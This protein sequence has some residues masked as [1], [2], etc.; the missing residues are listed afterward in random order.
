[1]FHRI[2]IGIGLL[3]LILLFSC[4]DGGQDSQATP[5]ALPLPDTVT[6]AAHIA[7]IIH[8]NCMPCH[9]PGS[10]GPFDLI[11]YEDVFKRKKMV[12]HVTETRYMPPWPADPAYRHFLDEKVLAQ[13]DIDLIGKW[14]QQGGLLGDSQLIPEPPTYPT[15]SFLGEPDLVIRMDS[16]FFIAG[17]NRDRFLFGKIPYQ[18]AQDTFIRAIEFVPGNTEVVHHMN[19][20]LISYDSE[21]KTDVFEGE[22]MVNREITPVEI[23]YPRLGLLN[24]DGSYPRLTPLVCSYLPGVQPQEIGRAHV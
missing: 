9:R 14:V 1:M 19:G 5:A 11:S 16:A 21:A 13:R 4:G 10:V 23:A 22:R 17:D 3:A 15:G 24:D 7:P 8:Q 2:A 12:R 20:H 6:F 18:I